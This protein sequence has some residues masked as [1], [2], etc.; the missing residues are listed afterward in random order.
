MVQRC[1]ASAQRCCASRVYVCHRGATLL[2]V[3]CAR[4]PPGRNTVARHV[5]T[6]ATGAQHCCASCVHVCHGGATLLRAMCARMPRGRNTVARVVCTCAS[7]RNAATRGWRGATRCMSR[8]ARSIRRQRPRERSR[9]AAF[10][11]PHRPTRSLVRS[12][13]IGFA[14]AM[15]KIRCTQSLQ[16]SSECIA[17]QGGRLTLSRRATRSAERSRSWFAGSER[18]K[19]WRDCIGGIARCR[20][21]DTREGTWPASC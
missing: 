18:A 10:P 5:C 16:V 21:S 7:R 2:R 1:C 17:D 8:R 20:R 19:A 9:F 13:L 15:F 6:C 11:R 12:A 4:V 14:L 3:V